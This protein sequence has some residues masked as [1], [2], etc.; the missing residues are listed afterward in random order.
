MEAVDVSQ[1]SVSTIWNHFKMALLDSAV[2]TCRKTKK[3]LQKRETWWWNE[4]VKELIAEKRRAWKLW[5]HGGDKEI[6]L[7]AKRRAKRAVYLAKKNAEASRFS[8]LKPGLVDIFKIAKQMRKDNLDVVGDKCIKDDSGN[9][10]ISD[11]AKCI[12]WKEHYSRLLNVKF[13]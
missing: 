5:K 12:A 2:D 3:P 11:A 4:E 1:G 9:L 10:A 8:N 7:N 13:P 6:Y